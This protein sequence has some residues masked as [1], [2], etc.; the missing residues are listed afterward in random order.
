[1]FGTDANATSVQES[2]GENADEQTFGT[3]L[4]AEEKIQDKHEVQENSNEE[5]PD[6]R[7]LVTIL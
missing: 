6:R 4:D 3:N 5:M 2:S 7:E 1:M